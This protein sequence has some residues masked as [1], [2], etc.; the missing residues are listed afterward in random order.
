LCRNATGLDQ[1]TF[2]QALVEHD[3]GVHL[4]ASVDGPGGE[5]PVSTE[6]SARV[7]QLARA[8]F[9]CVV[10]DLDD[11]FDEKQLWIAQRSDLVLIVAHLDVVALLRTK[12]CSAFLTRSG[13]DDARILCVANRCGQ[14]G[15]LS[16]KIAEGSLGRTFAALLP[17]DTKTVNASIN[18][19]NPAVLEAPAAK[20]S[21]SV[22]QLAET[23]ASR[24]DAGAPIVEPDRPPR[25]R[26]AGDRPVQAGAQHAA[27]DHPAEEEALSDA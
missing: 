22:Q 5:T 20:Y 19:G 21:K 8:A 1:A 17:E 4:L 14:Q 7:L 2:A 13:I 24:L 18:V 6:T 11:V 3:C 16:Q 10:V 9:S 15:E 12:R 23:V 26:A 25:G 27:L